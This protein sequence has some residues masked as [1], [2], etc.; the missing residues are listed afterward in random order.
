MLILVKILVFTSIFIQSS[1]SDDGQA[2][3]K[4]LIDQLIVRSKPTIKSKIVTVATP[5][6]E[7]IVLGKTDKKQEIEF[8][9]DYWYKIKISPKKEGWVF[10]GYIS[11]SNRNY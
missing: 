3:A 4:I 5:A 8:L 9:T 10:G 7:Y 1:F 6:K 2:T 11:V